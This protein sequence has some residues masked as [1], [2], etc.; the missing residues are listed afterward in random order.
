MPFTRAGNPDEARGFR[1]TVAAARHAKW[2]RRGGRCSHHR[3]AVGQSDQIGGLLFVGAVTY[4]PDEQL[5]PTTLKLGSHRPFECTGRS[6]FVADD[7]ATL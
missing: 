6:I 2:A 5:S 7:N 3:T 1:D 4:T